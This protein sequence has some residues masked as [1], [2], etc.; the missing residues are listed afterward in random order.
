MDRTPASP[1]HQGSRSKW[2]KL[3]RV[4]LVVN[5]TVCQQHLS[6]RALW[7]VCGVRQSDEAIAQPL[8][9]ARRAV[10]NTE[11]ASEKLQLGHLAGL[12]RAFAVLA[13]LAWWL[14]PLSHLGHASGPMPVTEPFDKEQVLLLRTLP[15]RRGH[16][17]PP[18]PT[19]RAVILG[20]AAP[21]GYIKN[22]RAPGWL[23]LDCDSTRFVEIEVR[24]RL[25]REQMWA[26]L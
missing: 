20:T 17:L 19:M 11:C 24:S 6:R 15:K 26:I 8:P 21:G 23:A 13:P 7:P 14:L 2:S 4:N 22:D 5:A 16:R 10:P 25:G 9:L 3:S 1:S 12:P 18:R